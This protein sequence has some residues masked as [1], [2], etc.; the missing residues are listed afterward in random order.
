MPLSCSEQGQVLVAKIT[1]EVDHHA[2]RKLMSELTGRVDLT[3]PRE[4]RL[5]LEGVSFMDSSGIAVVLRTWKRLRTYGGVLRLVGVPEQSAKVL[6]AAG[7]DRLVP[8]EERASCQG[9]GLE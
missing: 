2:A 5:D 3:L 8:W 6:R 7:V 4:V 9:S 1:G